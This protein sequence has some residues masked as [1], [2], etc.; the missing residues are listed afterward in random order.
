MRPLLGVLVLASLLPAPP[1]LAQPH[2]VAR[3]Q[4]RVIADGGIAVRFAGMRG[5][6][7]EW[8]ALAVRGSAPTEYVAWQYTAGRTEGELTFAP[9]AAGDYVARAYFG[10]SSYVVRA[11]SAPFHQADRCAGVTIAPT[12]TASRDG[13]NVFVRFAGLCGTP[14]DWITIA[15]VGAEPQRYHAYQYTTGASNGVLTFAGVPPG[16]WVARVFTDWSG[17]HSYAVRAESAPFWVVPE[18]CVCGEAAAA[19]VA[20]AR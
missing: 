9:L 2:R 17:S 1:V 18:G 15:P 5:G 6:D 11:E 14:T 13:A 19:G 16:Q 4:L 10:S 20:G 3:P 7:G 8:I 12:V